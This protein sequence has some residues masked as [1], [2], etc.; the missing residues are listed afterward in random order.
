MG[1]GDQRQD[2]TDLLSGKGPGTHL[3]EA[4][5]APGPVWRVGKRKNL[6]PTLVFGTRTVQM[7]AS[8]MP[9]EL[10]RTLTHF[11]YYINLSIRTI[12][13]EVLSLS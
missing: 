12:H 8:A 2:Q 6:L 7:A 5:C 10:T 3:Q 4:G 11:K 9:I 13:R 1:V